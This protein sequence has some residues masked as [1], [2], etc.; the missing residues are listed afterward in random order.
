MM[1]YERKI[2]LKQ[3][4]LFDIKLGSLLFNQVN[5]GFNG[6]MRKT[7]SVQNEVIVS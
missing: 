5:V 1:V 7:M 6:L 3:S 4:L 2:V